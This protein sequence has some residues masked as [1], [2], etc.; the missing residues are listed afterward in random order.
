MHTNHSPSE[1]KIEA[2]VLNVDLFFCE[3]Q[4]LG[5]LFF[6]HHQKCRVNQ[7][8]I[9]QPNEVEKKTEDI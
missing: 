9:L 5:S 2:P 3:H 7:G 4:E 1:L 6:R 8:V